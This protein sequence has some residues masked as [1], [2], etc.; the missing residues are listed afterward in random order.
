M[1]YFNGSEMTEPI[2]LKIED[3]SE[4]S[5][6]RYLNKG[7]EVIM[8]L[9]SVLIGGKNMTLL[10]MTLEKKSNLRYRNERFHAELDF[11][12]YEYQCLEKFGKVINRNGIKLTR[13]E[14]SFL[15]E[16]I[17]LAALLPCPET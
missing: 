4:L 8:V 5:L 1:E 11:D 12:F 2:D 14:V 13:V 9:K 6:K 3:L 17:L 7:H 16:D 10:T 15:Q